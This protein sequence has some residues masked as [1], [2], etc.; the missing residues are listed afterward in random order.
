MGFINIIVIVIV[1]I[2]TFMAL[3]EFRVEGFRGFRHSRVFGV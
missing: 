3:L 1:I 2:I